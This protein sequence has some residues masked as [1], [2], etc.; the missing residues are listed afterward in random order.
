MERLTSM[1]I[2]SLR[3]AMTLYGVGRRTIT[4]WVTRSGAAVDH[5]KGKTYRI[6]KDRLETWLKGRRG[7]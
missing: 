6:D 7:R 1:A 5:E 3:E 4:D 2:I